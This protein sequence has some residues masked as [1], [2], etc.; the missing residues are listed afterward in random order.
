[1]DK[2]PKSI[3]TKS[4]KGPRASLLWILIVSIAAFL[5][6]F[7]ITITA[8]V[9][10][11]M[12]YR[13]SGL[14]SFA[15]CI[16]VIMVVFIIAIAVAFV[17]FEFVC[18]LCSRR[19]FKRLIFACACFA[20][21]IALG[22]AEEDWRGKYDW[23]KFKHEWEAKGESFDRQSFVPQ[24][25]PDDENFAL[26]PIVFT[27]Y[28]SML[29][30]DGKE[31][32]Y[33]D[34]DNNFIDR[35]AINVV[36][37]YDNGPGN[38]TGNWQDAKICDLKIWQKYYR[39]LTGKT[40]EFPVAPQPQTPAQD[41]LLALSKYDS[42]IEE[43]REASSLPYSRFP[44]EYDNICPLT[45]LLPHLAVLKRCSQV[46]Q[47]RSIAELQNG[48]SDKAL[49]DVKLMLRLVDSIHTEPF[50]IS[51]LVR[52]EMVHITLQ[53]IYEGLAKHE[54]SEAQLAELD[55]ELAKLDFLK[56][57]ESAVR[58]DMVFLQGGTFDYLRDY[59][60]QLFWV[61][62]ASGQ[63][64]PF[65]IGVISR[66]IP[67]GWSYQNEIRVFGFYIRRYLPEANAN[68]HLVF[69]ANAT[70]ADRAFDATTRHM[71]PY[72]FMERIMLP[73]LANFVKRC[74]YV[75]SAIDLARVAVALERYHLEEGEY[76][77]SL[78]AL[79]PHFIEQLPHDLIN[80]GPLHYRR[81]SDGQFILYSVGWNER[82]DG[83][84]IVFNKKDN[85]EDLPSTDINQGDWV[86]RYPEK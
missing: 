47:L 18:H 72:N 27:S 30:R 7:I 5:G 44:L 52:V 86:W 73:R 29:T 82:D 57:Y 28:G 74:A 64:L 41:V 48:Q 4:W 43:L 65:L 83:G 21:L 75:Q 3:W 55:S 80:G 10:V 31:I 23:K 70:L 46:L 56:D 25:V 2:E 66:L 19:N 39:S 77:D 14:K 71:G 42:T 36:H 38:G 40:N 24:P 9:S 63:K 11:P 59:P 51:C 69:P 84:V 33:K 20:T 22:Y 6:A 62:G 8:S 60:G 32:P 34:R 81:T 53:P 37:D 76:P 49:D 50:W 16:L 1:M 54:W 61:L 68:E 13:H 58:G 85:G 78:D 17:F 45:I 12:F 79:T 26:T 35:M 67:N 15:T